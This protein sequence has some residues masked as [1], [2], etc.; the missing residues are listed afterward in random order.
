MQTYEALIYTATM[1]VSTVKLRIQSFR[2]CCFPF[3]GTFL[4]FRSKISLIL[5][6]SYY[7]ISE[8]IPF[9]DTRQNKGH[10][11]HGRCRLRFFLVEM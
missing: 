8:I 1:T 9:A 3:Q 5:T 10:G 6:D 2:L 7:Q 4:K 11:R